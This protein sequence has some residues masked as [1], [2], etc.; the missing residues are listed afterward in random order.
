MKFPVAACG[1]TETPANGEEF[2]T[3]CRR[4]VFG[5]EP[6]RVT[7]SSYKFIDDRNSWLVFILVLRQVMLQKLSRMRSRDFHDVFG[8]THRHDFAAADA[9]FGAE[10][11]DPVS[12]LNHIQVVF[13]R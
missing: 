12:R 4:F 6:L 8:R 2:L 9:A 11:N 10:V 1:E 3:V 7:E 5:W 13:E